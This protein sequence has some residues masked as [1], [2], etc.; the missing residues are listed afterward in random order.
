[1]ADKQCASC[2]EINPADSNFCSNCGASDFKDVPPQL[3]ALLARQTGFSPTPAVRIGLGRVILVTILSAGLYLF[4]WF[5]LTW[6]QLA[7]ET[8]GDHRPVWH[9]LTLFVPVYSLF[10][11][12]RHV[13][14]IEEL[15]AGKSLPTSLS[16][17]TAVVLLIVANVLSWTQ[18]GISNWA[19][20]V[21]ISVL[22]TII[23]TALITLTQEGLNK[24]WE[25]VKGSD[26]TDARIGVGEVVFV[27]LGLVA[28]VGVFLPA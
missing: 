27:V 10:R 20:G 24:Y 3:A 4:Y 11:M 28:W 1:M 12:H 22:G 14:I 6:K 9:A 16:A 18:L 25:S 7:G 19:G 21:V 17:G 26:L 15:L 8:R 2:G 23:T 5:Y 13:R